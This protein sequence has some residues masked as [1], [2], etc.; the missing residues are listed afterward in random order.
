MEILQEEGRRPNRGERKPE[1]TESEWL[2]RPYR[3]HDREDP[4][5]PTEASNSSTHL[6]SMELKSQW[7]R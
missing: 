6:S 2:Q 1:E 4:R 5:N 3:N 7:A